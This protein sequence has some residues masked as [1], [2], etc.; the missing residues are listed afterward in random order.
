MSGSYYVYALKDPRSSPAKPFYIGKGTGT[1][2]WEHVMSIDSTS[3]GR[4]ITE[5]HGAKREVLVTVLADSLTEPQALKIE[6]ELIA[7]FGTE[8]SGG[9]LTNAVIP[10]GT[11]SRTRADLIVPSGARE[12][13]EIG[14]QFLKDAIIELAKANS[15]GITNADAA[16]SLGLKSDFAGGSKDYLSF[17][18]IGLLIA[19]G[20]LKRD[21]ALRKG[22]YVSSAR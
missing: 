5:I 18:V 17:S 6:A 1:R 21:D 7:A 14:L 20:R 22:R 15:A 19:E 3:K 10:Q 11:F 16:S 2:A 9:M 13:A 4:R 8:A 12:K